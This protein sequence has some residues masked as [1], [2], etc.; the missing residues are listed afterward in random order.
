L[1]WLASI[2]KQEAKKQLVQHAQQL[3]IGGAD[4][5]TW[6]L[7]TSAERVSL[8]RESWAARTRIRQIA[9]A[10]RH[11]D[12]TRRLTFGL[13]LTRAAVAAAGDTG[14]AG[15][16]LESAHASRQFVPL[17][18]LYGQ[19]GIGCAKQHHECLFVCV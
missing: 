4:V 19:L 8:A 16:G 14:R 1:A 13:A 7:L 12:V 6:H 2:K 11:R 17:A 15:P 10:R 5:T 3:E 9:R 18:A